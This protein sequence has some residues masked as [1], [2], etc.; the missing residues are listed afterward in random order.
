M[1]EKF[2]KIIALMLANGGH[3]DL[4]IGINGRYYIVLFDGTDIIWEIDDRPDK[5]DVYLYDCFDNKFSFKT[6]GEYYQEALNSEFKYW[7]EDNNS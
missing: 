4:D 1:T 2:K 5:D 7:D 3:L 6:P